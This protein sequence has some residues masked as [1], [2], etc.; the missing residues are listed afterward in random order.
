MRL[1][2]RFSI[3]ACGYVGMAMWTSHMLWFI[4]ERYICYDHIYN[5]NEININVLNFKG[6]FSFISLKGI[7]AILFYSNFVYFVVALV[8]LC[9]MAV[10]NQLAAAAPFFPSSLLITCKIK[11]IIYCYNVI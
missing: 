9:K 6:Y 4:A 2:V 7:Y 5:I 10:Q 8:Y 1:R 3:Y 11:N